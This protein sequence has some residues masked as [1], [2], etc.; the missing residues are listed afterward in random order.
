MGGMVIFRRQLFYPQWKGHY[1]FNRRLDG[2]Y[3][4][5]GR[6]AE[7]T[8][9]SKQDFFERP[10]RSVL[11]TRTAVHVFCKPVYARYVQPIGHE[12]YAAHGLCSCSLRILNNS[13]WRESRVISFRI[14][15][16]RIVVAK[17]SNFLCSS[18]YRFGEFESIFE[19]L[20]M[21]SLCCSGVINVIAKSRIWILPPQINI[22]A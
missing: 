12:P 14:I 19:I 3:S 13:I 10:A 17:I 5:Y 20:L 18:S 6:F 11:T 15:Y 21:D 22:S 1:P 9:E 2:P 16:Y 8:N 7:N 4:R